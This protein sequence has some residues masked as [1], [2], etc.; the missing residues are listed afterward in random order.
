MAA[1]E[2]HPIA[3]GAYIAVGIKYD[4]GQFRQERQIVAGRNQSVRS[5]ICRQPGDV[6]VRTNRSPT[7]AQV[8]QIDVRFKPP[9]YKSC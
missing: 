9:A 7:V 2:V 1:R 4:L 6:K 8:L 5:L 3:F